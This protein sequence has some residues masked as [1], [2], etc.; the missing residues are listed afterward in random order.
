MCSRRRFRTLLA[1][2]ATGAVTLRNA[3]E[4]ADTGPGSIRAPNLTLRR[5]GPAFRTTPA[6]APV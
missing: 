5:V 3:P 2:E 4:M 6:Q 1:V